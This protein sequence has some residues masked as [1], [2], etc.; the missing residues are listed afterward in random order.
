MMDISLTLALLLSQRERIDKIK[1]SINPKYERLYMFWLG[2]RSSI[3]DTIK[4]FEE[5]QNEKT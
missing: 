2:K 1:T 5:I 4:I 3:N